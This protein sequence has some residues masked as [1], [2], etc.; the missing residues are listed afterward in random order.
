M[1]KAKIMRI[2]MLLVII[3]GINWGFVAFGSN[4]ISEIFGYD[5][6]FSNLIYGAVGVGAFF[7]LVD[8]FVSANKTKVEDK[9]Q[10]DKKSK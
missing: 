1:D 7:V 9:G 6:V 3:G 10:K 5:T 8:Q 4:P 2:A